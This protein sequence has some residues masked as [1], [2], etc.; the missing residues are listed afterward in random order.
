VVTLPHHLYV[1]AYFLPIGAKI[2]TLFA[3]I[4]R[5]CVLGVAKLLS[6][7]VVEWITVEVLENP[8]EFLAANE[9]ANAIPSSSSQLTQYQ[10]ARGYPKQ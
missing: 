1:S 5:Y 4:N 2:F 8:G 9:T 10:L 3:K 7:A 6:L